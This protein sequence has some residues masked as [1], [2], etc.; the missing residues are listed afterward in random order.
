MITARF[1]VKDYI[2]VHWKNP[3]MGQLS[4]FCRKHPEEIENNAHILGE[5]CISNSAAIVA[6]AIAPPQAAAEED[7]KEQ[8]GR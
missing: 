7:E 5:F 2:G 4:P 8:D 6:L 3:D 1:L